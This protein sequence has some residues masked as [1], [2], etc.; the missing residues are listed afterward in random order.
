MLNTYN[1]YVFFKH[2]NGILI[3]LKNLAHNIWS[4]SVNNIIYKPAPRGNVMRH[5]CDF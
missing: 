2:S 3:E 1:T 5:A 4:S